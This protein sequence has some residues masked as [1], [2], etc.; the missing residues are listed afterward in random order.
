MKIVLAILLV[1]LG[2]CQSDTPKP[3]ETHPVTAEL[4]ADTTGVQPGKTFT[5]GVQMKMKPEW[6]VY[7]K[8]PGDS[9][10]P[11]QIAMK[12]PDGFTFGETHWPVPIEF[13][14]P[15]EIVGYGYTDTVVFPISVTAPKT[16]APGAT[17]KLTADVRWLCCKDVCIPGK[18]SLDVT[19]PV[20]DAPSAANAALFATWRERL[21]LDAPGQV[22]TATA[23]GKIDK[24]T[25][26][27]T[28]S[29]AVDWKTPPARVEWFP[30]A[31][32]ALAISNVKVDGEG[33]R[34]K[35]TFD[36]EIYEGQT[37]GVNELPTLVVFTDTGGAR[38]GL[39]VI[40]RLQ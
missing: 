17:V 21:P 15:G 30:E 33:G 13:D 2:A 23:T 10:F 6:H 28:F 25:R 36:A 16:L 29:V 26:K 8:N 38:R 18:A 27:G 7:W 12:G 22:A 14:Q 1:S 24:T 32:P 19:L 20:A 9:G 11:V 5:V 39:P 3:A 40:V 35:I 34:S 37:L 4:L 31:D